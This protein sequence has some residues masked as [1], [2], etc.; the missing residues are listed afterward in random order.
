MEALVYLPADDDGWWCRKHPSAQPPTGGVCPLCLRA[1]LLRLCPD[2]A[3]ERPCG[4]SCPSTSSAASSSSLSSLSSIDLPRSGA[5]GAYV[6]VVGRVSLL[7]DSEPAFRRSRSTAFRLLRP[8]PH[9]SAGCPADAPPGLEAGKGW[10][11]LWP[12]AKTKKPDEDCTKD[13]PQAATRLS[14]S[15]S[16]GFVPGSG[17]FPEAGAFHGGGGGCV[18]VGDVKLKGWN[19]YFPSPMKAFRQRKSCNVVEA[20]SPLCRG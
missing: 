10:S 3:A 17:S 6:G 18:G 1:R 11:W 12:F 19:R 4:C 20:R 13:A 15:R 8:R 2:C 14:R 9:E 7:I 5:P 16:V